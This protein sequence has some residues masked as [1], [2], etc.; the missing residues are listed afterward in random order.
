MKKIRASL[1]RTNRARISEESKT[2]PPQVF[3]PI[4]GGTKPPIKVVT[5]QSKKQPA[6]DPTKKPR[7]HSRPPLPLLKMTPP[8][9]P[10]T[11]TSTRSGQC[12]ILSY[13][14][15]NIKPPSLQGPTD[16]PDATASNSNWVHDTSH[17]E[18]EDPILSPFGHDASLVDS[19]NKDSFRIYSKNILGLK[20]QAGDAFAT[21][22]VGFLASFNAS[23]ACLAETNTNWRHDEAQNRIRD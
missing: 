19:S 3:P 16:S 11:A 21:E 1:R 13:L 8:T 18:E 7:K 2:V 6:S 20:F 22:A 17:L 14:T 15:A 4:R 12:S 5:I 23:A 9:S 10:P